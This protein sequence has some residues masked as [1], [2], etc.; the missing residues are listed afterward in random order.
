M[1]A[2]F[3]FTTTFQGPSM[4]PED[5]FVNTWHFMNTAGGSP[6]DYDNVRDMLRDF[7]TAAGTGVALKSYLTSTTVT[8]TVTVKAYDYADSPP[9]VPKYEST[10]SLGGL[11]S[12]AGLPTEVAL[13]LSYQAAK[14]SGIPQARRRNRVYL[15][16]FTTATSDNY[17]RP[18]SALV[19]N[20]LRAIKDL[21]DA[22]Q[23]S[24]SWDWVV[25][26]PTNSNQY[27]A[28][29]A[30]VDNAWD[31]QRRRGLPPNSRSVVVF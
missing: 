11:G 18:T 15:G 2:T 5:R 3:K 27:V 1:A 22:A 24:V 19:T 7:W 31:T 29:D 13:C 4:L 8:P 17:G 9:R 23:A 30:W 12:A 16:P 21:R 26:S 25:Y 6:S 20:M 14:E 10:F 28:H